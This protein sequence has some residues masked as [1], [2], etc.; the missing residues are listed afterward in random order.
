MATDKKES[1]MRSREKRLHN[2]M[3]YLSKKVEGL[4]RASRKEGKYPR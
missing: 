4:L 3:R 1:L 2:Q